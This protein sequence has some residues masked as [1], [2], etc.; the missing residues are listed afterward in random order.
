MNKDAA[1]VRAFAVPTSAAATVD[2]D[3]HRARRGYLKQNFSKRSIISLEPVI[4]ERIG[5]LCMRLEEAMRQGQ[6]I[7]L[8]SAFSALAADII[9]Q[10]L[11]GEHLDYL[12]IEDFKFAENEA[13]LKGSL[14]YHLVRF[15]PGFVTIAK[16]MAVPVLRMTMP[17]VA[18]LLAVQEN[19]KH[20][21]LASLDR[22]STTETKSV[23]IWALEDPRIPAE[24]RRVDRLVDE[25]SVITFGGTKTSSR[26]LSV[27]MFYVLNDKSLMRKLRD[28]LDALSSRPGHAYP[29]SELESL[30]FLVSV[31]ANH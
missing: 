15:V 26:A 21:I 16:K 5:R 13:F 8:D 24:E 20:R 30:P 4:Q 10:S 1:N 7:C 25:C 31:P 12:G 19:M 6:A 2:H 3:H 18:D 27:G 11:Y 23:I 22:K 28:E 29:L 14:S 9:T 17:A